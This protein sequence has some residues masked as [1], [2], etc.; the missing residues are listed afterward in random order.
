[1]DS[2]RLAAG[3]R[4][5]CGGVVQGGCTQAPTTNY[6]GTGA[7]WCSSDLTDWLHVRCQRLLDNVREYWAW[8]RPHGH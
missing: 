4:V 5:D 8:L 3:V 7:C 6:W 1:M 2:A